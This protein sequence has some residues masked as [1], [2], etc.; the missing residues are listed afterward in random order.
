MTDTVS[1]ARGAVLLGNLGWHAA[2]EAWSAVCRDAGAPEAIEVLREIDT[3]V[4]VGRR[5]DGIAAGSGQECGGQG[6]RHVLSSC[7]VLLD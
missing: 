6:H 5:L 4:V 7:L 2:A 3:L 1:L